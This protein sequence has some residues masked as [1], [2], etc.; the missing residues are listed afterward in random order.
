MTLERLSSATPLPIEA[1]YQID[2][3]MHEHRVG[4]TS[5]VLVGSQSRGI[6]RSATQTD[7][8]TARDIACTRLAAKG[9]V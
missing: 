1:R 5:V 9:K 4:H 2:I 7:L 8:R 6:E 3:H